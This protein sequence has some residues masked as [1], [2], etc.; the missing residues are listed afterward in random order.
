MKQF[1]YKHHISDN[2][3]TN[4]NEGLCNFYFYRENV[5]NSDKG[6]NKVGRKK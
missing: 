6:E 5:N 1:L 2:F 4:T 3:P